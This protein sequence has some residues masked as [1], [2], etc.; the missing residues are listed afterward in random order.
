MIK[1]FISIRNFDNNNTMNKI[2]HNKMILFSFI[3]NK[4]FIHTP[5]VYTQP[6]PEAP[7]I[8]AD[9]IPRKS[10]APMQKKNSIFIH[11]ILLIT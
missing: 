6:L 3:I 2:H 4:N 5:A 7:I 1:K 11:G 8:T 10:A 9:D